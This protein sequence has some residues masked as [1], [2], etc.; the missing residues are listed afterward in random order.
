[1]IHPARCKKPALLGTYKTTLDGQTVSYT[2]KRSSRAKHTR[3]EVR[4][5]T[6]L[7]VVIPGSYKVNGIPDLL[8][9][10]ER[11]ILDKLA[12]YVKGHPITEGKEPKSGDFIPY[13]GRR[14]KVVTRYN[15][16][17]AVSVR[18]EKK[19]LLVDLNSRNGRLNLVLEWWYRRQAEKLIKKRAD[20]LCAQ[21]GVTYD[22]LT[23]RGART[24]WGSCS[25]KGNI[26]FNWKLM[27]VPEPVIDYVIIH[28]LA[29]L[30]EMNHSKN[31]WKLVA[32]HY[33]RWRKHRKWLKEHEAE[34]S[35]KLPS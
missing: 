19:R 24:R 9:K 30:K 1:M 22:R 2:V 6:G 10:K 29:H 12:K 3:L 16:D 25:Q 33:P 18:L 13:L 26:N 20:E 17:T 35:T 4:A 7:T 32:E 21:L 15:P 14:L 8:R 28:E 11:W 23:V 5:G 34:L 31:F 27:M